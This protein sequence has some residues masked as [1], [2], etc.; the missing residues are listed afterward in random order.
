[1]TDTKH[2]SKHA[3]SPVEYVRWLF[4][5]SDRVAVLVRNRERGETTQRIATA[6]KIR[7]DSFQHWLHFKNQRQ[8]ADVYVGMNPLKPEA[9]TRT[10]EDI[11]SIRH[12]YLDLDHDAQRS[13]AAVEQSNLVPQPNVVIATSPSKLQ[14]AWRV[15]GFAQEQAEA[16]LRAMARKF[17]GDPAATDSTRVL[18]LPGFVNRKYDAEF[19]VTAEI[20]DERRHTP[21]D[22]RLRTDSAE[23]DH[24]P[25]RIASGRQAS[26]SRQPLSQSEHDWAFAKRSLA[27]GIPAEEVIRQIAAF[28][29]H[30][31]HNPEDYARRTV[32]KAQGQL[33]EAKHLADS[34]SQMGLP[35][36]RE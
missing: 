35:H 33:L 10:K 26:S 8:M 5:P 27:K 32:E 21:H 7:E 31:K 19:T 4:E 15:E 23:L 28:R 17:G 24:R 25:T 36:E 9:R 3:V 34:G 16:L 29:A 6:G 18:R 30:D 22:F 11:H 14:L 13:L 20:R 1:M 2:E 12:L